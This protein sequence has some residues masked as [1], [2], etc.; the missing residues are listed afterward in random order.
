MGLFRYRVTPARFTKSDGE[1]SQLQLP[2]LRETSARGRP[3]CFESA[4]I[5][6]NESRRAHGTQGLRAK[7]TIRPYSCIALT[8]RELDG[9]A[10]AAA[11]ALVAQ[12]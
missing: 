7:Q 1:T 5:A 6:G 2:R 11:T 9:G 4:G 8:A 3:F 12:V 10:I